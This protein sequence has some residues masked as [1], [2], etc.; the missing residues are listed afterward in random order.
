MI[1]LLF[2]SDKLDIGNERHETA[3]DLNILDDDESDNDSMA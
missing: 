2:M 3:D 1:R